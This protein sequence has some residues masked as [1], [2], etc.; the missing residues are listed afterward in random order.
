MG[1]GDDLRS[2]RK[3]TRGSLGYA[4]EMEPTQWSLMDGLIAGRS[5]GGARSGEKAECE[6]REREGNTRQVSPQRPWARAEQ[7][8]GSAAR[9]RAQVGIPLP[10]SPPRTT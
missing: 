10:L 6:R 5:G 1:H 2:S 7:D 8:P 9:T 3:A 4:V